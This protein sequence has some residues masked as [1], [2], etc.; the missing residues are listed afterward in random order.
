M[1]IDGPR[2]LDR[3]YQREM[4][5]D[6]ARNYDASQRATVPVVHHAGA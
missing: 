2:I 5:V 1:F 3:C 6:A 4:S